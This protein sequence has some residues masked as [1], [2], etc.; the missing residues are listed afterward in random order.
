MLALP[1]PTAQRS[2]PQMRAPSLATLLAK[3]SSKG[4]AKTHLKETYLREQ[5]VGLSQ[6]HQHRLQQTFASNVRSNNHLFPHDM[7]VMRFQCCSRSDGKLFL[8]KP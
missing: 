4:F 8:I 1:A 3:P 7:K 2:S 6:Q 5:S